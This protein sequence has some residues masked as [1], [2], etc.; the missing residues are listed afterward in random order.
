MV[1]G[2]IVKLKTKSPEQSL[3]R[4]KKP[5]PAFYGIKILSGYQRMWPYFIK[6]VAPDFIET[7]RPKRALFNN[8]RRS[9]LEIDAPNIYHIWTL[10]YRHGNA[11]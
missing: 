2:Y 8:G 7:A 9:I 10:S 5:H 6:L 4:E 1:F 11:L 3:F